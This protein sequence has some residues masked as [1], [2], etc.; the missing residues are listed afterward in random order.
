METI[1][2]RPPRPPGGAGRV[3]L[4]TEGNCKTQARSPQGLWGWTRKNRGFF[5]NNL[6]GAAR[7]GGAQIQAP[8][9]GGRGKPLALPSL[10]YLKNLG[11]RVIDYAM[12]RFFSTPTAIKKGPPML[13]GVF[14]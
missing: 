8:S 6:A 3:L 13:F 1:I 12:F 5:K 4:T 10:F 2:Y 14:Q 7:R 9:L 11:G